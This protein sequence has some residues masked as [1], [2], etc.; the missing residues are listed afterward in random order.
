LGKIFHRRCGIKTKPPVEQ[1]AE[2]IFSR[3]EKRFQVTMLSP[4]FLHK[5]FK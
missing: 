3:E 1:G 2:I 4:M 5:K